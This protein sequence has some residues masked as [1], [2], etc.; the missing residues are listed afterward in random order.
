M[1]IYTYKCKF[2]FKKKMVLPINIFVQK[3]TIYN[4]RK[5]SDVK[6]CGKTDFF[7]LVIIKRILFYS[8][9]S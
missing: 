3:F 7:F 8:T 1:E 9:C 6:I 2:F 4:G 5:L